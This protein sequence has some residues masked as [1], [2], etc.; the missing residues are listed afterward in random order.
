M[1]INKTQTKKS[2]VEVHEAPYSAQD[3]LPQIKFQELTFGQRLA[4]K[5]TAKIG[6]WAFLTVQS[7]VLT[8]WITLNSIREYRTG[9]KT[10]SSCSIWYFP[11]L[12]LI[13]LQLS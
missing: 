9:I 8:V 6:S 3:K 4:D 7:S 10:H 13:L 1:E 5:M 11:L 2:V 12:Q